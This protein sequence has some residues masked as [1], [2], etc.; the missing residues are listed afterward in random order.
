MRVHEYFLTTVRTF[1]QKKLKADKDDLILVFGKWCL[2]AVS[3]VDGE[4]IWRKDFAGERYG[5]F[6][7]L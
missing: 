6:G 2:H 3:D 4:V 5:S 1:L 7:V